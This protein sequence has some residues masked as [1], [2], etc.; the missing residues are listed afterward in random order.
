MLAPDHLFP[1]DLDHLLLQALDYL[2]TLFHVWDSDLQGSQPQT[3]LP[4]RLG[5]PSVQHHLTFVDTYP[6]TGLPPGLDQYPG[7][8]HH[9]PRAPGLQL[10][11]PLLCWTW[12][13]SYNE[14][15]KGRLVNQQ[16]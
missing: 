15:K 3:W 5:F 7:S 9:L 12:I 13:F 11:I 2:A 8:L 6:D 1:W 16:L 4:D 14:V 10:Q